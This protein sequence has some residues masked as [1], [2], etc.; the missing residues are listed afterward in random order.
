MSPTSIGILAVGMSVD[1]LIAALGRGASRRHGLAA[2][3][4]TGAI[5]GLIEAITPLI[6]WAMGL[7]ASSYVQAVDHWIAFGLLGTIGVKMVLSAIGGADA[8]APA[9]RSV[10]TLVGTAVG[11]SIDAMAVGVSLAFLDVDIFVVAGAIGFATMAMATT[12]ILAGRY[13]SAKIGRWAEM[14]GGVAL[15]GL[16]ASILYAHLTA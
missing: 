11:T 10:W 14:L 13:L 7:L 16:G 9:G 4:G 5:F 3:L 15:V 8:P 12:G 6:G 1:A 2:A